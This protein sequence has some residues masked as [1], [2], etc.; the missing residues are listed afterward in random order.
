MRFFRKKRKYRYGK[1]RRLR[2][3]RMARA[4]IRVT[5]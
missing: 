3:P 5:A 1:A 4:G 2:R